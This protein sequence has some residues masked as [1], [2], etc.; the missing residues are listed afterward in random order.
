[1]TQL[2]DVL[3]HL[4]LENVMFC[5]IFLHLDAVQVVLFV[6]CS[7]GSFTEKHLRNIGLILN[8]LLVSY[9]LLIFCNFSEWPFTY[10]RQNIL[11][12][13][14]SC[15]LHI[16][17]RLDRICLVVLQIDYCLAASFLCWVYQDHCLY[18]LVCISIALC[19]LY[20][21]SWKYSKNCALHI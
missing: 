5:I 7:I 19:K 18:A 12:L 4:L 11:L 16:P 21:T 1:M 20:G 15:S 13:L 9:G 2:Y 14:I 3:L 10:A 6:L 8:V 17:L